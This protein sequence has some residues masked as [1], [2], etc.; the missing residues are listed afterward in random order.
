M[1]AFC[2]SRIISSAS[3]GWSSTSRIR[4]SPGGGL[5]SGLP[6]AAVVIRVGLQEIQFPAG[7]PQ[8]PE[9]A[10]QTIPVPSEARDPGLDRFQ[11][12][13]QKAFDADYAFRSLVPQLNE[14]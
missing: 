13:S 4:T 7:L 6:E 3:S 9:R 5:V 12:R 11:A 10:L 1:P 8:V 14:L 2:S